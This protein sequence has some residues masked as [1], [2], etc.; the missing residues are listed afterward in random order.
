MKDDV[1]TLA[2]TVKLET[3]ALEPVEGTHLP[4][5]LVDA[6]VRLAPMSDFELYAEMAHLVIAAALRSRATTPKEFLKRM[7][8]NYKI[9][10]ESWHEKVAPELRRVLADKGYVYHE[11][12]GEPP[13]EGV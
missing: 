3:Q 11:D 9:T 12:E 2:D 4:K 1:S 13:A 5:L 6:Q 7:L 10:D 8:E